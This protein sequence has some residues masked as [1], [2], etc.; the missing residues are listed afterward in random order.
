MWRV[1]LIFLTINTLNA[2]LQTDNHQ[3]KAKPR[4]NYPVRIA[5][6]NRMQYWYGDKI[7]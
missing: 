6:I 1:F 7:A 2:F 4:V 3:L 5:Y